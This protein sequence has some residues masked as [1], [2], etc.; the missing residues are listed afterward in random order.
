MTGVAAKAC[1]RSLAGWPGSGLTATMVG[2]CALVA[3][4][5][6]QAHGQGEHAAAVATMHPMLGSMYRLGGSHAKQDVGQLLS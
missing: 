2:R 1:V 6:V 4:E 3:N 5:A